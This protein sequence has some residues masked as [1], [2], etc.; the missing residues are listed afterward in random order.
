MKNI[1]NN[2][3][4]KH[5]EIK[6]INIFS[7]ITTPNTLRYSKVAS[8]FNHSMFDQIFHNKRQKWN[9]FKTNRNIP[10]SFSVTRFEFYI[11]QKL[12][13]TSTCTNHTE[14]N[15]L[16]VSTCT[17]KIFQLLSKIIEFNLDMGF[18]ICYIFFQVTATACQYGRWQQPERQMTASFI[19][20]NSFRFG[21]K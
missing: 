16:K 13:C 15:A 11:N 7:V 9:I 19:M 2:F 17:S 1:I 21:K 5:L 6:V 20:C 12:Y 4:T 3:Q 14:S 18:V 10:F 8:L